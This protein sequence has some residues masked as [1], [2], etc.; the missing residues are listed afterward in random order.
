[1]KPVSGFTSIKPNKEQR[2]NIQLKKSSISVLAVLLLNLAALP[3]SMA[4]ETRQLTGTEARWT[5]GFHPYA[6]FVT[7]PRHE[8]RIQSTRA[9]IAVPAWL[10][11]VTTAGFQPYAEFMTNPGHKLQAQTPSKKTRGSRPL[12]L[13]AITSAGFRPHAEFLCYSEARS[14]A[15]NQVSSPSIISNN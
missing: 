13:E 6:E 5:A 11:D 14:S 2:M 12:W 3:G 9:I 1:M 4:S 7:S 15:E 10:E 8:V